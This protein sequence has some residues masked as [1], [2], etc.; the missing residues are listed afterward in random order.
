MQW[1]NTEIDTGNY[2]LDQPALFESGLLKCLHFFKDNGFERPR[3]W[4]NA[5]A[6]IGTTSYTRLAAA[7]AYART[8]FE[9]AISI[10][11]ETSNQPVNV[12]PIQNPYGLNCFYGGPY[13]SAFIA[14]FKN[15]VDRLIE[16]KSHGVYVGQQFTTGASV[17]ESNL[18]GRAEL[19]TMLDYII[20]KGS[21]IEVITA[22]DFVKNRL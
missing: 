10:G 18:I 22:N 21:A 13:A 3:I 4:Y 12:Y 7:L 6:S 11:V 9:G 1:S 17:L 14:D 8:Y 16:T 2:I 20:S 15:Y 5:L 19:I